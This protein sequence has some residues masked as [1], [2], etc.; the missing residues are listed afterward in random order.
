MD[1]S[2]YSSVNSSEQDLSSLSLIGGETADTMFEIEGDDEL[3]NDSELEF[4]TQHL[5]LQTPSSGMYSL[6][7][8]L[9]ELLH[10]PSITQTLSLHLI[11]EG[12]GGFIKNLVYKIKSQRAEILLIIDLAWPTVLTYVLTYVLSFVNLLAVVREHLLRSL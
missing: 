2:T 5:D 10:L 3:I 11:D 1:D 8:S 9:F 12:P 4:D 7:H 6:S